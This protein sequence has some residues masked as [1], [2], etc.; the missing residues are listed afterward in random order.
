MARARPRRFEPRTVPK[1][2]QVRR[3][4]VEWLA[5]VITL[6]VGGIPFAICKYTEFSLPGPFDSGAYVYAAESLLQGRQLGTDVVISAQPATLLVNLAGVWLF[7]FNEI[8]PKLIQMLM[9]VGAL[10]MMY[11]VLRRLY[12]L[13]AAVVG[14]SVAA[15][16]LSAPLIAKYGNVK[17]QFMVSVMVVGICCFV[18]YRLDGRRWKAILAGA[19][20]IN[21]FYF[22]ATGV[23]AG[24]AVFAFLVLR[25]LM[26]RQSLR[27]FGHDYI[28]LLA[29]TLIGLIPL[30]IFF[31]AQGQMVMFQKS[32]PAMI[33]K[34]IVLLTILIAVGIALTMLAVRYRLGSQFRRVRPS[35]WIIGATLILFGTGLALSLVYRE[36][37]TVSQDDARDSVRSFV[38]D[39]PFVHYPS[40]VW[41]QGKRIWDRLIGLTVGGKG[42]VGASRAAWSFERQAPI[43]FRYYG[44]LKL[45]ILLA[46]ISLSVAVGKGIRRRRNSV[47]KE[48]SLQNRAGAVG[49][50]VV[51]LFAIW[52]LLDM[53]FVWISPR[54]YEEYYL[55]LNASAAMTG[56]FLL[57]WYRDRL[58]AAE[59]KIPWLA[60]G[61]IAG[62]VSLIMVWP[63]FVGLSVSPFSGELYKI[64][65]PR[66]KQ[67][68]RYRS[69]GYAQRLEEVRQRRQN[70]PPWE[71]VAQV[72]RQQSRPDDGI[73]VWGWYP[74]IYVQAQRLSPAPKAFES[75]MHV[76]KPEWLSSEVSRIL[77]GFA[78]QKPAFIVD[79]RK[80][81]FPWDRR[82]LE[83]W[84]TMQDGRFIP[85]QPSVIAEYD[86]AYRKYLRD[87]VGED[88]MLRYDAMEPLRK[89]VRENY[90]I[91]NDPSFTPQHVLF[92]QKPGSSPTAPRTP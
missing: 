51:P 21:A 53:A 92:R 84:P 28:L 34:I 71:K 7:G 41:H 81:E 9:Q 90:D 77:T 29:G 89:F 59:F 24:V 3:F 19:L 26:R 80:S 50:E 79:S 55:P 2:A 64:I 22:K 56:G 78:R 30:G 86:A 58:G 39:H 4:P 66:T 36:G 35:F 45:P 46:L 52:W 17:E 18:Q 5:L 49:T 42:Y 25:T 8:G 32:L 54:S 67:E 38:L 47:G 16:Y 33:L 74:G 76:L 40:K 91:V 10:A 70:L 87:S 61:G 82:P 48:P 83:L 69:R 11:R 20:L 57:G 73:F 65:D 63:L 31:A 75:D 12:G 60:G 88:E 43:V 6:L 68:I 44:V 14:V 23:S 85:N 37:L 62:L 1:P 72:I 27:S 13:P 15:I